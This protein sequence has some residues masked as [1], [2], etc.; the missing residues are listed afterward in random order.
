M[1]TI[2]A[3]TD[4]GLLFRSRFPEKAHMIG[5]G[6]RVA[7]GALALVLGVLSAGMGI[8]AQP[9]TPDVSQE[10][11]VAAELPA[12]MLTPAD[13]DDVGFPDA[14]IAAGQTFT[15]LA[16]AL[17]SDTYGLSRGL[18]DL[19]VVSDSETALAAAGW[20]RFHERRLGTPATAT[21]G[22]GVEAGS[23]VESF[24][25]AEGA[26]DAFAFYNDPVVARRIVPVEN[27]EVDNPPAI[28]E[29][30]VLWQIRGET[31]DTGAQYRGFSL[32][33]LTGN[34]IASVAVYD[35]ESGDLPSRD[36]VEAM[37]ERLLARI[38]D[39]RENGGPG[40]GDRVL[41]LGGEGTAITRDQY[42]LMDGEVL[43]QFGETADALSTRTEQRDEF[44]M[45]N[46]YYFFAEIAAGGRGTG[47]DRSYSVILVS[48]D[49][50]AG[51]S[52]YLAGFPDRLR[53]TD[54]E[55][56]EF[57]S[58]V[59]TFGDESIAATWAIA[60]GDGSTLRYV[61]VLFRLDREVVRLRIRGPELVDWSVVET[62]ANEQIG[63]LEDGACLDSLR[64]PAELVA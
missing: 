36:V 37:G 4:T 35:Y 33:F 42:R 20:Q 3:Q 57:P 61:D 1:V 48:F 49:D 55:D 54:F 41:R 58:D 38:E 7:F 60:G 14:T 47:D 5:T 46:D 32:W 63:C 13:L 39:V 25:S 30:T 53:D 24:A 64:P 9:G 59:P 11:L 18:I 19:S 12:M 29:E 6:R 26:A 45:Q 56:I 23:G 40:L 10:L 51:A 27:L 8:A 22:L 44:G 28:G 2:C 21:A 17:V 31:A 50:V 16:D 52:D 43:P 34:I 15:L 62:L